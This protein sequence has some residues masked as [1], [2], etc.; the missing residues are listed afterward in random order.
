MGI[1]IMSET[2]PMTVA[3]LPPVTGEV[4]PRARLIQEWFSLSLEEARKVAAAVCR[5]PRFRVE[6]EVLRASNDESEERAFLRVVEQWLRA[7][8]A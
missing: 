2:V 4:S 6:V 1:Y 8:G 3:S 7:R 5:M